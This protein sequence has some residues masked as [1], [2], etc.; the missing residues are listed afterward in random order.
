[1]KN[2]DRDQPARLP[3]TGNILLVDPDGFLAEM[4]ED[5]LR[6]ARPKWRVIAMRHPNEALALLEGYSELD[7]IVTEIV[8]DHSPEE[9]KRFV[10]EVGRRWPDIAVFVMTARDRDE[11]GGLD[12]AEYIAKPRDMDFLVSRI[13]RAIR[14]QRESRVR[15]ISLPT[16]LQILELE[17]KSCTVFV[18]HAGRVG[19]LYFRDGRLIQARS[20]GSEGEEAL[21][22]LLSMREHS[23]RVVDRCDADAVITS[24]LAAL[25]MEWSV[26]EDH[27][28]NAAADQEKE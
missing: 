21:F 18:S 19:E 28:R 17:R 7:A 5:G 16:F 9:G 25:L 23:L 8:F 10:A 27:A 20:G 12:T 14:R 22:E 15:G 13:D 11:L 4:M 26:R 1:M 24:S 2:E 6:L 3:L